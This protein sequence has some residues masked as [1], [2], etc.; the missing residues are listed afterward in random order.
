MNSTFE[1]ATPL[2]GA[3]AASISHI[4]RATNAPTTNLRVYRAPPG[5]SSLAYMVNPPLR[6]AALGAGQR[7][8]PSAPAPR[9]TSSLIRPHGRGLVVSRER[10]PGGGA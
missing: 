8:S 3:S 1:Q 9:S 4:P 2:A 7:P 5:A 6:P 10:N